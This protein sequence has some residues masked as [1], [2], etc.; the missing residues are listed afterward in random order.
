MV[1]L[2]YMTSS[3]P[4]PLFSCTKRCTI[5]L[6]FTTRPPLRLVAPA[7]DAVWLWGVHQ[8]KSPPQCVHPMCLSH[9]Y[10]RQR[11]IMTNMSSLLYKLVNRHWRNKEQVTSHVMQEVIMAWEWET[12]DRFTLG[13]LIHLLSISH[14]KFT[15]RTWWMN[16]KCA[17]GPWRVIFFP[18][19][20]QISAFAMISSKVHWPFFWYN[21]N[22]LEW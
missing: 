21:K 2:P 19:L 7:L 14:E 3:H 6:L 10:T 8:T 1:F 9:V 22:A 17:I 13:Q 5:F 18:G 20:A 12:R 11:Q 4:T 15:K 16:Q